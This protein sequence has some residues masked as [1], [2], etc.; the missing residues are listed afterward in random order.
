MCSATST[1][2]NKRTLFRGTSHVTAVY[3][4]VKF[5]NNSRKLVS[6]GCPT[7]NPMR[8]TATAYPVKIAR[9]MAHRWCVHTFVSAAK[10]TEAAKNTS[11]DILNGRNTASSAR[12]NNASHQADRLRIMY[13]TPCIGYQYGAQHLF[14]FVYHTLHAEVFA[15]RIPCRSSQPV[16][17]VHIFPQPGKRLSKRSG[18]IRITVIAVYT[19]YDRLPQ[20]TAVARYHW[21][22]V[23]QPFHGYH[24]QRFFPYRWDG[25]HIDGRIKIGRCHIAHEIDAGVI[26]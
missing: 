11:G 12:Q 10:K 6:S 25:Q 9:Y 1:H 4:N 23:C 3:R 13:L 19:V 26:P 14:I 21:Q 22:M 8:N 17:I 24:A 15:H 18:L 16:I 2:P 5:I 7:G 20:S